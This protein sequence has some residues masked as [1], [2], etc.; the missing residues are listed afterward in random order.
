MRIPATHTEHAEPARGRVAAAD[1][2]AMLDGL[3]SGGTVVGAERRL[4]QSPAGDQG[5]A[6]PQRRLA[7]SAPCVAAI[8]DELWVDCE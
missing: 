1:I 2:V 4:H 7:V 6:E 5:D 3:S 8:I